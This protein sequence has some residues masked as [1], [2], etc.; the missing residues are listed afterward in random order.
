MKKRKELSKSMIKQ[1]DQENRINK[2]DV[3]TEMPPPKKRKKRNRRKSLIP[4]LKL[5][6]Q[7]AF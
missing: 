5:N 4:V 1:H 6:I 3:V 7:D 2:E